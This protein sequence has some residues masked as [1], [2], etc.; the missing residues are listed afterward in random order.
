MRQPAAIG[1]L[2]A[3]AAGARAELAFDIRQ[4]IS[5]HPA[6]VLKTSER[7]WH[8]QISGGMIAHLYPEE[9]TRVETIDSRQITLIDHR[10]KRF[11]SRFRPSELGKQWTQPGSATGMAGVRVETLSAGVAAEWNGTAVKRD[12][13]RIALQNAPGPG[14][15][16]LQLDVAENPPGFDL[17]RQR[18]EFARRRKDIEIEAM[19]ATLAASPAELLGDVSAARSRRT[20]GVPV[21]TIGEFRLAPGAPLLFEIGAALTGYPLM[22]VE[23]EVEKLTTTVDPNAFLV[24]AGYAE[25][26]FA[27]LKKIR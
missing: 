23:A 15:W 24:P 26:D 7:V 11:A 19:V 6:F 13:I 3:L 27:A 2:L 17:V 14:E 5:G 18:L 22:T 21:R 12:T 25:V 16:R 1:C 4:T 10:A 9:F 20:M 8:V